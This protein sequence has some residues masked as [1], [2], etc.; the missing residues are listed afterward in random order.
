MSAAS[1]RSGRGGKLAKSTEPSQRGT[2]T[3][4]AILETAID[5]FARSGYEG[6]SMSAVARSAGVAQPLMHY[7]FTSKDD[8]WRAAISKAFS[9]MLVQQ[10]LNHELQE[11][12]PISALQ[13]LIRRH[14]SFLT[15]HP[16]VA[17]LLASESQFATDRVNWLCDT[18]IAP[19]EEHLAKL[20]KLGQQEGRIRDDLPIP[21]VARFIIGS[22]TAF[23]MTGALMQRMYGI[24]TTDATAVETYTRTTIDLT[25]EGLLN[26][27]QG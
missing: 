12:D 15:R 16:N 8:L 17:P 24:D 9:E 18:Y 13:V 19:L 27:G 6:T 11:L 1:S 26:T 25:L 3:R 22:A 21:F 7:Y 14:I 23:F 10:E 4:D 2:A 5:C 20:I